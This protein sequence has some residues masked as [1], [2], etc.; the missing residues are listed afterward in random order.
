MRFQE[1]HLPGSQGTPL[2]L[3]KSLKAKGAI[4]NPAE[5]EN[6]KPHCPAEPSDLAVAPFGQREVKPIPGSPK[7]QD[8]FGTRRPIVKEDTLAEASQGAGRDL[9]LHLDLIDPG[10][11]IA[12]MGQVV[13]HLAIVG[14]E[15]EPLG[16]KVESAHR[17]QV[18]KIGRDEVKHKGTPTGIHPRGHIARRLGKQDVSLGPT[19]REESAA[20]LNL[21]VVRIGQTPQ[22]GDHLPVN[23]NLPSPD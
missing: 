22:P 14:H 7:A 18:T 11:L 19:R 17:S 16:Q 5:A 20:H 10:N 13:G 15:Q 12:R 6:W 23:P 4:L 3:A 1:L 2:P 8:G 9:P 21:V